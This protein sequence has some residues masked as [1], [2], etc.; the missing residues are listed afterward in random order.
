MLNWNTRS[1][2]RVP[3]PQ[4]A[5]MEDPLPCIVLIHLQEPDMSFPRDLL[6][7][8]S[9]VPQGLRLQGFIGI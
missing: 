7:K 5:S 6:D 1:L 3:V 8:T 2:I 9:R 4:M